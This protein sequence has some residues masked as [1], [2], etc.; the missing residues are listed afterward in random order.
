MICDSIGIVGFGLIGSSIAHNIRDRKL[1][2]HI[3]CVDQ[4]TDVCRYVLDADLADTASHKAAVLANCD[5]IF[6]CVPVGAVKFV[7][8]EITPYLKQGSVIT[9][10]GSVKTQVI[11]DI[12]NQLPSSV[13]YVP[14]HPMAGTEFSG[15]QAGFA[16]LFADKKWLLTPMN[17]TP[18][19]S[20]ELIEKFCT[21]MG[22]NVHILPGDLHDKIVAM[23]SHLPQLI[24]YIVMNTA[25]DMEGDIGHEIIPYSANGFHGFARIAAS[26]PIMWRDVYLTNTDNVLDVIERFEDGLKA[27]KTAIT[28]KDHGAMF[29]YFKKSR[30]CRLDYL[31]KKGELK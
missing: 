26:D 20:V 6:I 16:S 4:D 1:A 19:Q 12:T 15:P 9:D 30:D 18:L 28:S 14:G 24:S 17:D 27:M 22:A 2:G 11:H 5:I 3:A 7:M 25:E 10:V 31:R 23:T 21:A 13:S 8:Q 29:D